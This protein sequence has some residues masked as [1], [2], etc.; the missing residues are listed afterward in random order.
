VKRVSAESRAA[1][2]RSTLTRNLAWVGE[3]GEIR[4]NGTISVMKSAR[5]LS[6]KSFASID[7]AIPWEMSR[8]VAEKVRGS[9][10]SFRDVVAV[11]VVA[12]GN[13]ES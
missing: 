2:D 6:T 11:K 3:V 4:K 7:A 8:K 12:R 13:A 9:D 5:M 1:D 10:R